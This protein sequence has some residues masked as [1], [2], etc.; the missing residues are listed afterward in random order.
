MLTKLGN[1]DDGVDVYIQSNTTRF[2][3]YFLINEIKT[4]ITLTQAV[5]VDDSVINVSGAFLRP[6]GGKGSFF[7]SG[8]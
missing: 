5:A 6:R 4:D 7:L 8:T 2:F 1:S 3:R